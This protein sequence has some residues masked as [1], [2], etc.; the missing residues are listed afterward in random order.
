[1]AAMAIIGLAASGSCSSDEG[2][3]AATVDGA[4]AITALVNWAVDDLPPVTNDNGDLEL[5]IVYVASKNGET[6]DAGLQ[7]M[8]VEATAQTAT[9]RFTDDRSE[10]IDDASDN[11]AV[12]D[13]GVMLVLGELS[14]PGR[15]LDVDVERYASLDD[16]ATFDIEIT[17]G[18]SGPTV[19][20]SASD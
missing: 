2:S 1:M 6:M 7:A 19:E 8:V 9:V 5:P 16:V 11:G 14:E 4:G 18:R 12:R 17:A 3:G 15:T 13:S 10:A 20:A